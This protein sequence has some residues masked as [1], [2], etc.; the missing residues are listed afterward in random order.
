MPADYYD[1]LEVSRTASADEIR[2]AYRKLARKHHPDLNPDDPQAKAKFQEVQGAFDVLNDPKKR[3]L[4]DRF[5]ADYERVGAGGGG[6]PHPWAGGGPRGGPGGFDVNFEDL[7]GAG[8]GGAGGG[9][10]ADLFRQFGGGRAGRAGKRSAAMR[11]DD[12]EHELTV[13]FNTAVLGGEASVAVQRPDGK[14]ET[15]TAKIPAGIDDGQKIR[16]RGQGESGV[17]GGPA[18]DL[19]ITVRVAPHPHFRR[20]GKRLDVRVPITLAEALAGAK[21][22]VPTPH[23]TITLTAPPG[24]SSGQKLRVKGHGVKPRDGAPGDLF[25]ELMIVIPKGLSDDDRTQMAEI[26][27]KYK[28]DV[29]GDLRW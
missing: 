4:Y 23:G 1:T 14:H 27:A 11:G 13:P 9:G 26:A 22:D 8:G 10:F 16:L 7:F 2:T 25:A 17:A 21:I 18:G 5:G 24:A 19:L 3:E 20:Q 12:L 28:Q 29:R 15:I 6:G